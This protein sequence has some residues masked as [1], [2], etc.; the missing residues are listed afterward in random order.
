MIGAVWRWLPESRL[1]LVVNDGG[2]AL[3]ALCKSGDL[4]LAFTPGYWLVRLARSAT[5][6]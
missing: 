5:G 1:V 3:P 4:R 6:M 2:S